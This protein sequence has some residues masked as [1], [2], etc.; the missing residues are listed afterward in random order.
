MGRRLL[1]PVRAGCKPHS[2]GCLANGGGAGVKAGP[3]SDRSSPMKL[4]TA[5][6]P[7]AMSFL[8]AGRRAGTAAGRAGVAK[9]DRQKHYPRF[10][11]APIRGARF[12]ETA[13]WDDQQHRDHEATEGSGNRADPDAAEKGDNYTRHGTGRPE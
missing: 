8:A 12:F 2:S 7:G 10:M 6:R 13:R 11:L 1:E 3:A 9:F 5:P 4:A